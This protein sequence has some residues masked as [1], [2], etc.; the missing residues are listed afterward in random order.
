MPLRTSPWTL[1]HS[2]RFGGSVGAGRCPGRRPTPG[3]TATRGSATVRIA[4]QA[5][6]VRCSRARSAVSSTNCLTIERPSPIRHGGAWWKR[7]PAGTGRTHGAESRGRCPPRY[8]PRDLHVRGHALQRDAR[9][10]AARRELDRVRQEIPKDLLE[11]VAVA[12]HRPRPG[13]E[14]R[15]HADALGIGGVLRRLHGRLHDEREVQLLDL[16]QDF[17]GDDFAHVEQVLDNQRLGA[18]VALDRA[19]ALLDVLLIPAV[20]EDARPAEDRIQRR[21]A[22]ALAERGQKLVFQMA[23]ALGFLAGAPL[24]ARGTAPVRP[25]ACADP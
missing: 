17:A 14:R 25:R 18:G 12:G 23:G 13:I 2:A 1:D 9:L 6:V 11:T 20:G 5:A 22:A 3:E 8:R 10:A 19:D 24:R 7:R 4:A 15:M 16:Q 21:A